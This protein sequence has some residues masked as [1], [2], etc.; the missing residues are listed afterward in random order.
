MLP[1]LVK[2]VESGTA[3]ESVIATAS[4]PGYFNVDARSRPLC[5]YPRQARYKGTGDINDAANFRCE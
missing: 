2:W 5:T 3:P 1:Q 4:N